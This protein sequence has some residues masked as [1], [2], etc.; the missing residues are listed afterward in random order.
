[1]TT[2]PLWRPFASHA[3]V[4]RQGQ[5]IA[6]RQTEPGAIQENATA[7]LDDFRTVRR[8]VTEAIGSDALHIQH[9]G[10]TS[11]AGLNAKPVIDVDLTVS[12]VEDESTYLPQLEAAGF[13]L[14]FRDEMAGDPH[15]HLTFAMPNTN[16]HVWNPGA[17]EPQR[18]A[19]F[20]EWL[21]MNAEERQLYNQAK[22]AAI[23]RAG[24]GRYNDLKAAVVY[25]IYERAFIADPRHHH[26]PHP[27]SDGEL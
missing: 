10:S 1:M 5:R 21:R 6:F 22:A 16:L 24:S 2:H 8:V 27:R 12:D 7:W 17:I 20:T 15:R 23:N 25:D 14:I 19:L 11:V 26:D 13:R 9:V 18:H 3:N 4:A